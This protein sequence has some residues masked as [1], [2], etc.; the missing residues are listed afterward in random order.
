MASASRTYL[1]QFSD[2]EK[3]YWHDVRQHSPLSRAEEKVLVKQVRAGENGA[4]DRLVEANLRF[5]VK[6]AKDYSGK[7]L[8]LLELVSEGNLGLIEAAKR[9]DERYGCK[10]I[11]YAVWWIRQHIFK[12]LSRQ[13]HAVPHPTNHMSD[14]KKIEYQTARLGQT[15][16]RTPTLKESTAAADMSI[17]R[18]IRAM[19]VRKRDMHLDQPLFA[20]EE[21]TALPQVL[22]EDKA[23]DRELE[24]RRL[25]TQVN[26]S[27]KQLSAREQQV[28]RCYFG[29]EGC[30]PITL[31]SIG[32][33]LGLTRE[34][35]RQ[36][37]DRAL[38]KL[39][40][41][42]WRVLERFFR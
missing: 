27:L 28:L 13:K 9:F 14:L 33:S 17:E 34:R 7:G 6:I 16:G 4:L 11:T 8:T 36:I 41:C 24:E 3:M 32:K 29:L 39:R 40:G 2:I 10:F 37:R 35:I 5:V 30:Q 12:A 23:P 26:Q 19:Q 1:Q 20:D 42:L 31:E 18:G 22:V 25:A 15:L 38:Q 21:K